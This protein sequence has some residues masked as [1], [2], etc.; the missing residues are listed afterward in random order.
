MPLRGPINLPVID[1]L[2]PKKLNTLQVMLFKLRFI[3]GNISALDVMSIQ[4]L[5][6]GLV[7]VLFCFVLFFQN[8]DDCSTNQLVSFTAVFRNV[9]Q[10]SLRSDSLSGALRDIP[11]D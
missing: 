6:S 5:I 3:F 8:E 4:L 9:T 11:K 1:T 7:F 2:R 10:R